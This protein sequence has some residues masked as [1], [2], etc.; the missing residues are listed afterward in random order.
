VN[1]TT[2]PLSY[3]KPLR[4]IHWTVAVFVI[5][6]LAIA[7][8]LTQLRSLSYGHMILALHRQLGL[9][10]FLLIAGRLIVWRKAAR[11]PVDSSLPS[12]QVN[13]AWMV[14]VAFFVLL[15]LQ[16]LL[17][18]LVAWGRGDSISLLGVGSIAS[19]FEIGDTLRENLMTAH[20]IVAGSILAL[21]LLHVGA[22]IF[23]RN[24]RR[25]AIVDRMLPAADASRMINRVP[26][27]TQM[28]LAFGLLLSIAVGMGATALMTYRDLNQ[29]QKQYQESTIAFS[30]ALRGAQVTLKDL[31]IFILTHAQG[32]DA[33]AGSE[34][35]DSFKSGLDDAITHVPA[36]DLKTSTE[37]LKAQVANLPQGQKLPGAKDLEAIESALQDILDGMGLAA[38]QATSESEE[39][40]ARGHD[41][42]VVTMLPMLLAGLVAAAFLSRSI[43]SLLARMRGLVHS[44]EHDRR[45]AT[46]SVEGQGEFARLMRD[47]ERMRE[48]IE[49]RTQE[50]A[51]RQAE[52]EADRARTSEEMLKREA[53]AERRRSSDRR[54][55]R[56]QLAA[57]FE[58]QVADIVSMLVA[59]A[60]ELSSSAA[61]M[62]SSANAATRHSHEAS[63]V[64]ERTNG[65][66][67][68]IALGSNELS[69]SARSVRENAEESKSR[70]TSAV[71][72]AASA[73]AQIS[74]LVET[75]NEIST[76]VGL[77]DGVAQQTNLLALNARI[78]A[79]RA[80]ESGRGFSVVA[81]EVKVLASR[82]REATHGIAAHIDQVKTAATLSADALKRLADVIGGIDQTATAIFSAT[83]AQFASTRQM[84]ER[85]QDISAA[86]RSMVDDAKQVS[87]SAGETEQ[88]ST[89]VV[90]VVAVI[91]DQAALLRE[92][93]ATFLLELRGDAT[94]ATAASVQAGREE[95]GNTD[96][97]FQDYPAALAS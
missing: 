78:E 34:L 45:D 13:T 51:R 10:I 19:P 58:L 17:G 27:V 64:A 16:P 48:A 76:T 12:W 95:R 24:V 2:P 54:A 66:A 14:H 11:P 96:D 35:L 62:A 97:T 22:V 77:I 47:I 18:I 73:K 55:Q 82:T 57:D 59:K 1:E 53:E 41:L 7:L 86:T 40:A 46:L 44:I 9:F 68:E 26:M 52:L 83:D 21:C 31:K 42:I 39:H 79:A 72:E 85:I 37:N 38:L 33:K 8:V 36:G 74:R 87:N 90:D 67:A 92:K 4:W 88:L 70:A 32:E 20:E 71:Q 69:N 29:S 60:G 89:A 25:V 80:G 5:C 56:E 84:V 75:V 43:T 15:L 3:A 65:G 49:G 6:Q 23:N 91:D 30:D 93:I 94:A 63:E 28:S 50:S 81:E 61:T